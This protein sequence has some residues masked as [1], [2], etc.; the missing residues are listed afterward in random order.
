MPKICKNIKLAALGAI[1]VLLSS[2]GSSG[3]D[4]NKTIVLQTDPSR[5]LLPFPYDN[6]KDLSDEKLFEALEKAIARQDGPPNS[7]F[8]YVRVDINGNGYRDALV[9][10]KIPYRHWCGQHGCTM[11]V[12]QAGMS[13]FEHI[14]EITPIRPPV[15]ISP[16]KTNHWNDLVIHVDGRWSETKDVALKYTGITY[17]SDPAIEPAIPENEHFSYISGGIKAFQ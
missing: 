17:P 12:M 1:C 9:Y 10:L 7:R 4:E 11:F 14:A 15:I 5:P 2:C 3:F 6:R 8:D 16:Q 13:S